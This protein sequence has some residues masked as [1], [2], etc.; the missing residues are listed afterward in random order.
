[1][2]EHEAAVFEKIKDHVAQAVHL[3]GHADFGEIKRK[4]LHEI[5]GV[6]LHVVRDLL[7]DY[8]PE[9]IEEITELL[10]LAEL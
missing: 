5:E 7:V 2:K 1:M 10:E 8:F 9:L 6:R 4:I 3:N